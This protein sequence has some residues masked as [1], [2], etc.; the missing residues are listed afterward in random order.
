[1]VRVGKVRVLMPQRRMV[2]RVAVLRAHR[3][4]RLVHMIV[5]AVVFRP[6]VDMAMTMVHRLVVVRMRMAFADV[7]PDAQRHQPTVAKV[8]WRAVDRFLALACIEPDEVS[9]MDKETNASF[10]KNLLDHGL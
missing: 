1:M 5:M 3:H 10:K 9:L 7:Q 4:G 8:I 6:T 2:M